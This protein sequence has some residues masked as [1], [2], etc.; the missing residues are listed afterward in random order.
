MN[1]TLEIPVTSEIENYR[2][3]RRSLFLVAERGMSVDIPILWWNFDDSDLYQ[4]ASYRGTF[5]SLEHIAEMYVCDPPCQKLAMDVRV[6]YETI[7]ESSTPAQVV[8][9]LRLIDIES[10]TGLKM[11][12]LLS[13]LPHGRCRYYLFAKQKPGLI[14]GDVYM[15]EGMEKG[16]GRDNVNMTEL[17][18]IIQDRFQ[19][20]Q[21]RLKSTLELDIRLCDNAEGLRPM[22][23][24]AEEL[25]F[26]TNC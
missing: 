5:A 25:G 21:M 7:E 3:S 14:I 10:S 16:F 18:S 23:P 20:K 15:V 13:A 2:R 6:C 11:A 8:G 17:Q 12:D 22:V 9:E 19:G 4:L 24:T 26:A 1:P